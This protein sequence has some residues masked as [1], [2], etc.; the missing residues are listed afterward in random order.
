[1]NIL[2]KANKIVNF[3][4][5]EKDRQYGDFHEC[6]EKTSNLA[7]IMSNKNIDVN[8]CYNVLIAL[9]LA[10]QSNCHKED[11]LLDLVAYTASLNDYLNK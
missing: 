3:R 6:M 5:E 11:N 7:S 1:M 4:T 2:E 10:R 8:D 9:K